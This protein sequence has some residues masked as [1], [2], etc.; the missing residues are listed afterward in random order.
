MSDTPNTPAAPSTPEP[1]T[2]RIGRSAGGSWSSRLANIPPANPA[3]PDIN[4]E[5]LEQTRNILG[6]IGPMD[7]PVQSSGAA[8]SGGGARALSQL[9]DVAIENLAAGDV[10][11]Y[12]NDNKWRNYNETNLTDGGN[13]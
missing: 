10:L 9:T 4:N 5:I 8:S 6:A 1:T 7:Y 12:A 13:F 3:S 11:R 2:I